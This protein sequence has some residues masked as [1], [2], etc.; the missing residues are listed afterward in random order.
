MEW[1]L[2]EVDAG[3]VTGGQF[4]GASL[5]TEPILTDLGISAGLV[6]GTAMAGIAQ[7]V[8]A[9][10]LLAL[11]QVVR[12]LASALHAE[13]GGLTVSTFASAAIVATGAI[14]AARGAAGIVGADL[15]LGTARFAA[16]GEGAATLSLATDLFVGAGAAATATAVVTAFEVVTCRGTIAVISCRWPL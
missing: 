5:I 3:A 7:G 6:A 14:R 10:V 9:G 11:G 16:G 2:L 13:L 4:F 1:V 8:D 12:A 15:G